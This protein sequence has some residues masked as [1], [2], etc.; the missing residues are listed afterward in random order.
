MPLAR[1][2]PYT[3][4][5]AGGTAQTNTE[6]EPMDLSRAKA[7]RV[8]TYLTGKGTA[9]AGDTVDIYLQEA[10]DDTTPTWDDRMHL[11]DPADANTFSGALTVSAAAPEKRVNQ[12]QCYGTTLA[13]GDESYEPSG[14]AGGGR[15]AV[16]AVISGPMKSK[17]RSVDS[18]RLARHR[19]RFEV[20]D[21]NSN[22]AFAGEINVYVESWP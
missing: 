18:G 10:G 4:S 8:E 16:G 9:D 19:F 1:S 11:G 3:F 14:S 6:L 5:L 13:A 17:R 15:L 21:A 2:G 22:S 12:I 7:I 20:T